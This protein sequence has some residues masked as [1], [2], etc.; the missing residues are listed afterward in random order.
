MTSREALKLLET[1]CRYFT[2]DNM[3]LEE[4]YEAGEKLEKD[5]ERLEELEKMVRFT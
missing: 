4:I 3:E 2:Q 5:L 1:K